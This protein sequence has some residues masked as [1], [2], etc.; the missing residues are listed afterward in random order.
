MQ[1]DSGW[2]ARLPQ[3]FGAALER[4]RCFVQTLTAEGTDCWRV[5]QG[6]A[7]GWPGLALDL[8]G[9]LALLHVFHT[10]EAHDSDSRRAEEALGY[11]CLEE[12]CRSTLG[13]E[14]LVVWQRQPHELLYPARAG[15]PVWVSEAGQRFE[16]DAWHRGLDPQLFL[17]MRPAR[18]WLR[19]HSEGLQVLNLFSYTGAVG[20]AAEAGGAERVV[21]VD[22]SASALA[23]SRCNAE[24]NGCTAQ[25]WLMDE[26]YP[27]IWQMAGRPL[28]ARARKRTRTLRLAPQRFDLVFIDPP[29]RAHGFFGSVDLE[30]DYQSLL[31]PCIELL[32]PGG[33]ILA[34]NHAASVSRE[35]FESDLRRCA[36]KAGLPVVR[37]RFLEEDPDFPVGSDQTEAALKVLL[38]EFAE[39]AREEAGRSAEPVPTSSQS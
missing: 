27:V 8:Y 28:P 35:R 32:A 31:R 26:V 29:T 21:N 37:A 6:S 11:A 12:W 5:F 10:P 23:R 38:L 7:E 22:V 16:L 20:L 4:R 34:C 17:D 30:R 39:A 19:K 33:R 24:A 2:Q 9:P 1:L 15:A 14:R 3:L 18:R 36:I 13:A 25:E